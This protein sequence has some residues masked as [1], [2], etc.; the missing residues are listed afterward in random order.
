MKI[1]VIL[2]MSVSIEVRVENVTNLLDLLKECITKA[3]REKSTVE[4]S[5]VLERG[6]ERIFVNSPVKEAI[7][8]L[9]CWEKFESGATK[10][11]HT[12]QA[13]T[14]NSWTPPASA[15]HGHPPPQMRRGTPKLGHGIPHLL[16]LNG[17]ERWNGGHT[18]TRSMDFARHV[19]AQITRKF[20]VGTNTRNKDPEIIT[21]TRRC[22]NVRSKEAPKE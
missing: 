20:I 1:C 13:W 15:P 16:L 2:D 7:L 21:T 19:E 5:K 12:Q 18:N 3:D 17:K 10:R 9:L 6:V 11:P 8:Q 4:A 22:K 14:P